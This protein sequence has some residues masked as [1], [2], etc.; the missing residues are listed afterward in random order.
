MI[1]IRHRSA[2]SGL[3]EPLRRP[4]A[5]GIGHRAFMIHLAPLAGRG[6][7]RSRRKRGAA[8]RSWGWAESHVAIASAKCRFSPSRGFLAD[9]A[10]FPSPGA[11]GADLS[12][13]AGR[14]EDLTASPRS[15]VRGP[16]RGLLSDRR[17]VQKTSARPP[18]AS[19][20]LSVTVTVPAW[21]EAANM[22]RA[23]R[24]RRRS[25]EAVA[26]DR[27]KSTWRP[28]TV[29]NLTT[30]G[31]PTLAF[32]T[33]APRFRVALRTRRWV[34]LV[35]RAS[36]RANGCRASNASTA[37]RSTAMSTGVTLPATVVVDFW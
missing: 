4:R 31:G 18:N 9:C 17:W 2:G 3:E 10:P 8:L 32:S 26:G 6:R 28:A 19:S 36:W 13:Q 12:P 15:E 22:R 34:Q 35:A 24:R 23:L 7:R 21:E 11:F 33:P 14:G 1:W 37:T 29:P 16:V 30:D 5:S 20:L 25:L 27:G